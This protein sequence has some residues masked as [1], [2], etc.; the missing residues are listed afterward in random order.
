MQNIAPAG[1]EPEDFSGG[2][3]V[4]D[5]DVEME[6]RLHLQHARHRLTRPGA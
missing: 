5:G 6:V 2:G 1:V 4:A 3:A